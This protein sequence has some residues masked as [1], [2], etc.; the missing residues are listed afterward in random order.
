MGYMEGKEFHNL[1]QVHS[2]FSRFCH[3][4]ALAQSCISKV[5]DI[6]PRQ[7]LDFQID[8]SCTRV[9]LMYL[10]KEARIPAM[11][12]GFSLFFYFPNDQFLKFK[13]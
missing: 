5:S 4:S 12:E 7:V 13:T 10:S 6:T 3:I 9:S 1:G 11:L 8:K 2:C